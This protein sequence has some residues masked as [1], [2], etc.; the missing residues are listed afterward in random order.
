MKFNKIKSLYRTNLDN[1]SSG[2]LFFADGLFNSEGKAWTGNF[3]AQNILLIG[4][5]SFNSYAHTIN[6][7][8]YDNTYIKNLTRPNLTLSFESDIYRMKS[9]RFAGISINN[10][11]ITISNMSI[12]LPNHLIQLVSSSELSTVNTTSDWI[13]IS[14]PL[15]NLKTTSVSNNVTFR[16]IQGKILISNAYDY[17]VPITKGKLYRIDCELYEEPFFP[18]YF[19]YTKDKSF[20]TSMPIII[21]TINNVLMLTEYSRYHRLYYTVIEYDVSLMGV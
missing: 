15:S 17:E 5:A 19:F 13:T 18:F 11:N 8:S 20:T 7:S 14:G 2:N 10:N 6:T 21:S 16:N 1:I 12:T 4:S 3:S 9:I